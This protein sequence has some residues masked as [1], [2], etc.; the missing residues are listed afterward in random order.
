MAR[1]V[2]DASYNL[3]NQVVISLNLWMLFLLD[4][5]RHAFLLFQYLALQLDKSIAIC[6]ADGPAF[7][8]LTAFVPSIYMS[9]VV[10]IL[11]NVLIESL[12]LDFCETSRVNDI[13]DDAS[14]LTSN[15]WTT[16]YRCQ[17]LYWL[18]LLLDLLCC[19]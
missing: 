11:V 2:Q 4:L 12:L 18:A 15:R 16:A 3:V 5:S 9:P 10:F 19:L 7:K 13:L 1:S 14:L 8:W 17:P 6:I